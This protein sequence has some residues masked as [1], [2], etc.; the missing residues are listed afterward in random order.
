MTDSALMNIALLALAIVFLLFLIEYK[1][2]TCDYGGSSNGK[3][4]WL[5]RT[6]RHKFMSNKSEQEDS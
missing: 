2:S 6:I 1:L 4:N 3:D 5:L